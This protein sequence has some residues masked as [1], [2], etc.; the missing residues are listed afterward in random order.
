MLAK[1]SLMS[2]RLCPTI[3]WLPG[4]EP[5]VGQFVGHHGHNQQLFQSG[6]VRVQKQVG[7]PVGYQTPA[8]GTG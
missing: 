4:H 7:F 3:P 2:Q 6:V 5:L 1:L 8:H